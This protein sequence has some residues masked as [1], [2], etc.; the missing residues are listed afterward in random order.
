MAN[1]LNP[2]LFDALQ[3]T[4]GRV[5]VTNDGEHR[6]V[7]HQPNWSSVGKPSLV[8]VQLSAG[9]TYVVSCPFCNDTRGRLNINHRY[10]VRDTI[11]GGDNRHLAHCFNEDCLADPA[12]RRQL[13]DLIFPRTRS[14]RQLNERTIPIPAR[15]TTR[16]ASEAQPAIVWPTKAIPLHRLRQG[17][18]ARRYLEQRQFDTKLL[19]QKW[20]V[21]Y[22]EPSEKPY[23]SR[24][25]M[26]IR[27]LKSNLRNA[28]I[29]QLVGWQARALPPVQQPKYRNSRGLRKS[30]V[31]YALPE[32][33]KSEGPVVLVEGVTDVWRLGSNAVA[34][35]GKFMSDR[36]GTLIAR[37]F[38]GRPLVVLLDRDAH[39]DAQSIREKILRSRQA[40]NDDTRVEI[41]VLPAG[42][43]DVAECTVRE[44]WHAV[45][46]ALRD[47]I[48]RPARFNFS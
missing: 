48:G 38:A 8:A 5:Q 26:P 15:R 1:Q 7:I 33:V 41:G 6:Q 3:K 23:G 19:G 14:Q 22:C 31:L 13:F 42:R 32:A 35:L 27:T 2:T 43:G 10:A 20:G 17:H 37:H 47:N 30:D 9:E 36:Q 16:P 34:L 18:P 4:F 21:C 25:L 28:H 44:A 24:I 11:T 45:E 40:G 39:A 29:E 46:V 12:T